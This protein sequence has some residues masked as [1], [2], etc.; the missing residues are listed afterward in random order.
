RFLQLLEAE[1]VRVHV[2]QVDDEGV[3]TWYK[4]RPEHEGKKLS[5][6][7][8][9]HPTKRVIIKNMRG[10]PIPGFDELFDEKN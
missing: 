1:E 7:K 3:I 9:F 5:E 6:I 8:Y 10:K 4:D 2:I